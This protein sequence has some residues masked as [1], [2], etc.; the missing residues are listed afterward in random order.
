[1]MPVKKQSVSGTS[2]IGAIFGL[3]CVAIAAVVGLVIADSPDDNTPL[4]TAILGFVGPT[5]LALLALLRSDNAAQTA[6]E[7]QD[8]LHNGV[9]TEKF[10]HAIKS[11]VV[12]GDTP[13]I[14]LVTEERRREQLPVETDRRKNNTPTVTYE[15]EAED[16]R[17]SV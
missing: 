2:V 8:D 6:K 15:S 17:P 10:K 5:I 3:S 16:G 7:T 11:A 14:A 13:I 4:I 1:M 9:I 12:D